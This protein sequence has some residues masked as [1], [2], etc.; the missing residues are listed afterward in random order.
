MR[1]LKI[2]EHT[3]LDGVVQH[4]A[5]ENAFPYSNWTVAFRTPEGL[6]KLCA[7]YGDNYDVL[8][9]RRTYDIL[10]TF[11][12]TAPSGPVSDRLN[13]GRKYVATHRAEGMTWGP[14][15]IV[16]PDLAE[17]VRRLKSEPGPNIVVLG[18]STLLTPLLE[19]GLVDELVVSVFPVLL[20]AGKRL[21]AEGIAQAFEFIA[22]DTTS[23]GVVL[24]RYKPTGGLN[25]S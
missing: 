14:F 10:G 1:T 24:N 18:S 9:G 16:G 15:E 2:F 8:L 11:W 13:A 25:I 4:S 7:L 6:A 20:G 3:S 17:G 19:E 23:S 12:S 21:F 22:T 5:D